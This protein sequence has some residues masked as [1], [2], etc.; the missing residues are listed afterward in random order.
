MKKLAAAAIIPLCAG[1][2]FAQQPQPQEQPQAHPQQQSADRSATTTTTT[3]TT[4]NGTLVDAAC[5][6][7]H[8]EHRTESTSTPDPNTKRTETTRTNT[9]SMDCP[10]TS[11][12]TTFGL[13]TADGKY[14]SFD[15]PSNTKVIQV[16]K[17]NK[18]WK[19]LMDDKKPVKV[20]VV[21]SRNGDVIVVETVKD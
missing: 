14:V 15:D 6:K 5:R 3:Q 16:V 11:T 17:S 1:F 13:L 12:T 19:K 18:D 9:E 7:T 20:N 8:T 10:V 21:G 2:L 4:W